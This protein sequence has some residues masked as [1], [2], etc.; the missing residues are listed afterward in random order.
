MSSGGLAI[1]FGEVLIA[2]VHARHF[3]EDDDDDGELTIGTESAEMIFLSHSRS[4][5]LQSKNTY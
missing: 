5:A 2:A 4:Y 3:D 1:P